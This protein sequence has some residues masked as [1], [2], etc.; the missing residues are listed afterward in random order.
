MI[1]VV[2]VTHHLGHGA[3]SVLEELLQ[4]LPDTDRKHVMITAPCGSRIARVATDLRLTFVPLQTRRDSLWSN[5]SAI[6]RLA[7]E[8]PRCHVVHAWTARGFEL[9][10]WMGRALGVRRLGTLHDH[11]N[12]SFHG[13]LRRWIMRRSARS[14]E[15][16]VCVSQAVSDACSHTGYTVPRCVI[17]NGLTD[18]PV[19]P[20]P[21][22]GP[23]VRVGFLGMYAPWKGFNVV[24]RWI[25]A[26]AGWPMQWKLFGRVHPEL[27]AHARELVESCADRVELKGHRLTDEI[28]SQLDLLVH[29]S[30]E[31]D[32]L[33]TV[34][35]EAARAGLPVVASDVGGA[36]E[37]IVQDR[38]GAL[39]DPSDDSKGLAQ[40]RPLIENASLR[41]Q[42]GQAARA[43]YESEF[44][45][46]RM[47]QAYLEL[48][49]SVVPPGP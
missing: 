24:E 3:E 40:L 30:T 48:W 16:L 29:P 23:V 35:I 25:R 36:S 42:W 13:G 10:W 38:T 41:A 44:R 6:R 22:G 37:I 49:H 18:R 28:L 47:V 1:L 34:L 2:S 39:F 11:P 21:D 7:A 46:E 43:R 17:R 9:A 45:I 15:R 32:P 4:G 14:F 20:V 31:F 33:P 5:L 26:T 8:P 19:G 27:E 12:A